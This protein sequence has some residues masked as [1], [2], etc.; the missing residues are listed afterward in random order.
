MGYAVRRRLTRTN[1]VGQSGDC[2]C[3][4]VIPRCVRGRWAKRPTS[5][6][7]PL[8]WPGNAGGARR[9]PRPVRMLRRC[10]RW[11]ATQGDAQ[12]LRRTGQL[13]CALRL[14]RPH[15]R[16]HAQEVHD[17]DRRSAFTLSFRA[18]G[19]PEK[20]DRFPLVS[21]P[22]MRIVLARLPDAPGLRPRA[23]VRGHDTQQ[24]CGTRGHMRVLKPKKKEKA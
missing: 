3:E 4:E 9:L 7:T 17:R 1:T 16:R 20:A 11:M 12:R 24:R 8:R 18:Y 10:L 19:K 5:C 6:R 22:L 15:R 13:R 23:T 21:P 2:R 14:C